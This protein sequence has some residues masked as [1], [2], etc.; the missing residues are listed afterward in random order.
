MYIKSMITIEKT[1]S[2]SNGRKAKIQ[3]DS[4]IKMS[5]PLD[6]PDVDKCEN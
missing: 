1:S 4:T 2:E 6:S 5:R 3:Q